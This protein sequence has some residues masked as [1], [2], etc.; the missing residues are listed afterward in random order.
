MKGNE[1]LQFVNK[2]TAGV[3][4][5]LLLLVLNLALGNPI[6][7]LF[8]AGAVS[9]GT[10]PTPAPTV[11]ASK[12]KIGKSSPQGTSRSSAAP[13][14][15]VKDDE[16]ARYDP[17]LNLDELKDLVS[18]PVPKLGRNPFEL[19]STPKDLKP[20]PTP[21]P[22]PPPPPPPPILLKA[23]G[24]A[25]KPGGTQEAYICETGADGKCREDVEVYVVHEG[26][27]FGN[28]F[29]AIKITPQQIEVEDQ[30]SHQTAQLLVSQ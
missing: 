17:S 3:G 22:P 30:N 7:N 5:L 1:R 29:R 20:N 28:H 25:E 13:A 27:Q 19:E 23:V 18:R 8:F 4:A 16:F 14:V 6:F 9:A 24:I 11:V 26:E 2:A 12:E 10:R 15:R 21:T